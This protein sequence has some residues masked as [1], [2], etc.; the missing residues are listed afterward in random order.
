M[1]V[2]LLVDG[3]IRDL[4]GRSQLD[5]QLG[6]TLENKTLYDD[7]AETTFHPAS[8]FSFPHGIA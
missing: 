1:R 3:R 2:K 7:L 6:K 8:T 5:L 4:V